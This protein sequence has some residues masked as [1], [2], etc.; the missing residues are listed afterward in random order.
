MQGLVSRLLASRLGR[1]NYGRC[2]PW[3]T[4]RTLIVNFRLDNNL[5]DAPVAKILGGHDFML[6]TKLQRALEICH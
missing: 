3:I 2:C 4:E 1:E 6:I 5:K